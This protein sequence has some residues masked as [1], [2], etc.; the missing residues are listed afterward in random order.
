MRLSRIEKANAHAPLGLSG[1]MTALVTPFRA[2]RI[3]ETRL[4]GLC[5]AQIKAGT[6]GLVVAGST[7][8]GPALSQAEHARVIAVAVA[9]SA[10]R[11][12][13]IA[14]CGA[15]ATE[16]AVTLAAAAARSRAGALLCAPPPYSK[17]TQDGIVAH[18]RAVA[19]AAEL[20]VILYDVP[21]RTGVAIADAT[22][23]TL[24]EA[25][26]IVGMKD[27]SGDLSRPPRLRAMLGDG[28][29]QLSGD[30][31]T[32]AAYRAMGGHGCISVTANVVP[33]LCAALHRAWDGGD[34]AGFARL[35]DLLAPL[36]EAMFLESNPIPVKAAL[37]LAGLCASTPRLPLTPATPA[38]R[39]HLEALLPALL[40][41]EE[42]SLAQP[43]LRLVR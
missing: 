26:L 16:A 35:R 2:G 31:G 43:R 23:V 5:E 33:A 34:I 14:G 32:A 15:P 6:S 27:A 22:V 37:E 21:G 38:T 4:F 17:P 25:G 28:L 24:F 18:I 11:V 36:H 41:A 30:D 12:P 29:M 40:A 3:D 9:A 10:G 20:P 42:A 13:V 7:G 39:L 8:E 19:L 1:S